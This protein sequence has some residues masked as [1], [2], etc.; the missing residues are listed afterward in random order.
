[1]AAGVIRAGFFRRREVKNALNSLGVSY[2]QR[3][4]EF[5]IDRISGSQASALQRHFKE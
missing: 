3:G 1:M 2:Q 4:G 5:R